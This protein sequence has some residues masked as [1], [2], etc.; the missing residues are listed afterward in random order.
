MKKLIAV[1]ILFFCVSLSFA[2]RAVKTSPVAQRIDAP[3]EAAV[4][5][6]IAASCAENKWDIIDKK[7]GEITAQLNIR[8][9]TLIVTIKYD[10]NEFIISY[11]DSKNLKYNPENQTIHSSY[12]R[13]IDNLSKGI[14]NALLK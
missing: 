4:E 1:L 9:H 3:N 6:A 11:K 7:K 8:T 5:K 12:E 14:A 10:K 2:A 13:W